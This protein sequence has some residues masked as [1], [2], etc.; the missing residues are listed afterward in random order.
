MRR[1]WWA[2]VAMILWLCPSVAAAQGWLD[3]WGR[4]HPV[5]MV[6]MLIFWGLVIVGV[7]LAIRWLRGSGIGPHS[8]D[9]ALTA[10]RQRY[11][12]GEISKDE[13]E[14]EKRDLERN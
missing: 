11:E 2:S 9:A 5:V 4:V 1:S 14:S 12:R 3:G 7:V 10:L 6:V 8:R 13:F